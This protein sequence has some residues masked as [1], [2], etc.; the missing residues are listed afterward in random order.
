[1]WGSNKTQAC[2]DVDLTCCAFAEP[3]GTFSLHCS[4]LRFGWPLLGSRVMPLQSG[5]LCQCAS[6]A[7]LALSQAYWGLSH[8]ASPERGCY[9]TA[10]FLPLGSMQSV[11]GSQLRQSRIAALQ[12]LLLIGGSAPFI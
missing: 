2:H 3:I 9:S 12:H 10:D 7:T 4:G 8:I 11:L 1:M 5:T 6:E